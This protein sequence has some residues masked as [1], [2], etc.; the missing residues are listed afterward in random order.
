MAK[1]LILLLHAGFGLDVG[2]DLSSLSYSEL[3][4]DKSGSGAVVTSPKRTLLSDCTLL[5]RSS[6]LVGIV[7]ATF[8]F[9]SCM[10]G[11]SRDGDTSDFPH[12]QE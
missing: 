4:Y 8:A 12:L 9:I 3:S 1:D 10:K 5:G 6:M 7:L 11:L 2:R